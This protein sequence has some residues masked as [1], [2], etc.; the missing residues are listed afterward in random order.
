M[1]LTNAMLIAVSLAAAG[2]ASAGPGSF[3]P[4]FLDALHAAAESGVLPKAEGH[5]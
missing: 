4:A 3:V 1:I 5:A 2:A